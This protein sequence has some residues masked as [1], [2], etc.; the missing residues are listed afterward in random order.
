MVLFVQGRIAA[1]GHIYKGSHAGWY[2]VS[3]EAY[4][5]ESQVEE[6]KDVATGKSYTVY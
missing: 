4:Y 2:A 1:N 6:I 5:T 3:D